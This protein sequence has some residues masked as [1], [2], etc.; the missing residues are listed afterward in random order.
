VVEYRSTVIA[1]L[2]LVQGPIAEYLVVS[3]GTCEIH[4]GNSTALTEAQLRFNG[5]CSSASHVTEPSKYI[6]FA[7]FGVVQSNL[8]QLPSEWF[9]VRLPRLRLC[10]K[11]A[12]TSQVSWPLR[13][14]S[15]ARQG[16]SAYF[17]LGC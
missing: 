12:K 11:H 10:H 8:P 2:E 3:P 6:S 13:A 7:P 9:M 1:G 16:S 17:Y 4:V 15:S 5:A 14:S